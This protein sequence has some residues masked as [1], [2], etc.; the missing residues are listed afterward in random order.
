MVVVDEKRI[1]AVADDIGDDE[2]KAFTRRFYLAI[3]LTLS[4]AVVLWLFAWWLQ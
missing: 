1:A 4:A 2:E 3:L